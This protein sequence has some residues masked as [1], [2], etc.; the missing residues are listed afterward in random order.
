MA[1]DLE[2]VGVFVQVADS[3]GFSAAARALHLSTNLVSRRIAS[4]EAELGVRLLHRTTRRSSLT[5]E[6]RQFRGHAVR[7]LEAADEAAAAVAR[8]A[9]ALEGRVRLALRSASLEIG[10]VEE[11]VRFL[12][13]HPGLSVQLLVSDEPLDLAGEGID[14]AVQHG[15]LPDSSLVSKRVGEVTIVLAAAPAYVERRG[16][17]RRPADLVRHECLRRLG[18]RT[19][20]FWTL[21]GPD[22]REVQAEIGGRLE[23]DD[24]AALSR[25][26]RAG[27]GIGL[28]PA[29][30]VR[31]AEAAGTLVRL[32]PRHH[33][34]PVPVRVV[35]PPRRARLPRVSALIDLVA[36]AIRRLA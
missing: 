9:S 8:R 1:L 11:L 26:L 12:D 13:L 2:E 36:A 16:R 4:L 21:V 22:G 7:L 30:E 14:L 34:S 23:C 6:G 33:V 15:E 18:R 19:E 32:L 10:L 28:R 25:A 5:E 27:F 17:P 31:R 3:G 20:A 24:A 35:M 29:G